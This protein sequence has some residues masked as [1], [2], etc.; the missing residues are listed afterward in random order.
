MRIIVADGEE[1]VTIKVV[2]F[3]ITYLELSVTF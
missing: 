3:I 2:V 1:D